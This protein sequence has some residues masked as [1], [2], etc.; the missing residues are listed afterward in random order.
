[1]KK[2][3]RISPDGIIGYNIMVALKEYASHVK[4]AVHAGADLIISGAGLPTELPALVSGS[5]TKIAPIVSTDKSAK[6]IL[7]YWE[8]KYKR[9]ADLVV[10]EGPQAG[11]H[12][13][14]HKEELDSYTPEATTMRSER[15]SR[16]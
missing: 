16:L 13:G 9:T 6:V 3:R 10:I 15:S 4:A 1:M 12:L 8:R 5:K 7:K 2:A 11:G 14:F